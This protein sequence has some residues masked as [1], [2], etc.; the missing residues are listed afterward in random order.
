[1]IEPKEKKEEFLVTEEEP[2][3]EE[4]KDHRFQSPKVSSFPNNQEKIKPNPVILSN[5]QTNNISIIN[6]TKNTNINISEPNHEKN[7]PHTQKV[8]NSS[9]K[10]INENKFNN[11][12]TTPNNN[13]NTYYNNVSISRVSKAKTTLPNFDNSK[14]ENYNIEQMRYN[15]L[16]DYNSYIQ[17]NKDEKFLNRMQFDIYKRQLKEEK[18]NKLVERNKVKMDEEER[19][20]AFNRLI[21]DANRRIE[22]QENLENMKDKLEEDITSGPQ[23]KYTDQEWKEIYDKRFKNYMENINKKKEENIKQQQMKKINDENE[24]I[25]LC[26]TKK[27]SKKTIEKNVQ[28]MYDEAKKRKIKM[29]EKLSRINNFNYEEEDPSKYVKKIKSEA[30][31]FLDDA[32]ISNNMY[33]IEDG[34]SYNEYY[35]GNKH[36]NNRKQPQIRKTKNMAVSEFNNKRFDKKPRSGK[37]CSNLN[38]KYIQKYSNDSI[39]NNTGNKNNLFKSKNDFN[40]EE[41]RKNLIQIAS[42]KCLQQNNE[43]NCFNKNK[44]SPT[45]GVSNIIDQFFLRQLNN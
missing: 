29:D 13:I 11:E 43:N 21:I 14:F 36:F 17:I 39:N 28:R 32:D 33:S 3:P 25:N 20:K 4:Y 31:S 7:I 24:E 15:L 18:I 40:L 2:I 30:Y 26:P 45:S 44:E 1:M 19:I 41:E 35:V 42:M 38:N 6:K 23:K 12:K 34:I 9:K 27:A 22:A 16:K 37:S 10:L 5:P 8:K